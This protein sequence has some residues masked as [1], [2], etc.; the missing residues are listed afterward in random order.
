MRMIVGRR[1][2]VGRRLGV[3]LGMRRAGQHC[4]TG[5]RV[6]RVGMSYGSNDAVFVCLPREMRA[7]FAD[8]DTG[9]VGCNRPQFAANFGGRSR[10]E[11]ER[12]ELRWSTGEKQQNATLGPAETGNCRSAWNFGVKQLG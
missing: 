10:L 5:R 7:E 8:L 4:V 9:N 11:V 3:G 6:D 2:N 12:I 1:A